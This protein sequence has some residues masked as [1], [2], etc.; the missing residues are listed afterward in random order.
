V[1]RAR[2]EI[3]DGEVRGQKMKVFKNTPPSLR[4]LCDEIKA[5]MQRLPEIS[6]VNIRGFG[7]HQIRIEVDAQ[8]AK[9]EYKDGVLQVTVPKKEEVK[10]KK[11]AIKQ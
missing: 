3:V 9:A 7:D 4:A 8:A 2:F 10:P 11:V 6:L 1:E 5:G